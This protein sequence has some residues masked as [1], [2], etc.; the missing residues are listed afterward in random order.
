MNDSPWQE[1]LKFVVELMRD[2]SLQTDAQK[3]AVMYGKR[4]RGSGL[5]PVDQWMS[6]SRRDLKSPAYRITRSSIWK[7]K[8]NPWNRRGACRCLR[9]GCSRS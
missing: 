7:E 6:I 1:E 4:L 9:R 5:L 3:A 8:I 2:I